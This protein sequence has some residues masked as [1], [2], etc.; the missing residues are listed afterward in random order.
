MGIVAP[1]A[2]TVL[3]HVLPLLQTTG[4][5]AGGH[6]EVIV[7]PLRWVTMGSVQGWFAGVWRSETLKSLIEAW[8]RET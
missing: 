5:T 4:V 8:L 3:S 2:V 6:S 7:P 1:C